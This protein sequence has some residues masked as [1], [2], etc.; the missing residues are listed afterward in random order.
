ME[1]NIQIQQLINTRKLSTDEEYKLFEEAIQSLQANI[2]LD[3]IDEICK[4][5][6]DDTNDDEVMF[7]IIHLLET[8]LGEEYLKKFALCTAIM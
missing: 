3:D 1:K 2:V 8:L 6:F 4:A 5:F 7:E